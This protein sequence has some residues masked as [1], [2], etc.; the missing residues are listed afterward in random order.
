[1]PMRLCERGNIKQMSLPCPSEQIMMEQ[2]G[3]GHLNVKIFLKAKSEAKGNETKRNDI[4]QPRVGRGNQAVVEHPGNRRQ[5][6]DNSLEGRDRAPTRPTSG[7]LFEER[8][9]PSTDAPFTRGVDKLMSASDREPQPWKTKEPR[10][11][12]CDTR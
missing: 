4:K 2:R 1:M 3:G 10:Q 11:P 9:Q 8:D 6:G 12:E 5:M 7:L